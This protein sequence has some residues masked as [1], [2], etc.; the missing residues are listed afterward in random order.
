M[1]SLR[2]KQPLVSVVMPTYNHAQFIGDAIGSVLDQTYT[3]I[4]LIIIDN[5]SEDNTEE[6]IVSFSDTRIKYEKFRNNGIIAASR[7]VGISQSCGKYIA[8]LDSDDMWKPTK[9]EKQIKL[10]EDND[11]IFLVYTRYIIVKDGLVL[12]TLP[13]RK[14]LRSG[15]VFIPLF[16]SNNFIGTSTVLLRNFVNEDYHFDI[17]IKFRAIEDYDL[18]LRIAKNKRIDYV[19]EPLVA[20]REHGGNTSI[21]I[22]PYFLR[23][24]HVVKKKP[25]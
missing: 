24:L 21:G 23:Y 12:K 8:F 22:K 14:K 4:E 15:N 6:I 18:W 2:I 19:D 13:K 10:L 9:I 20:Y 17:D 16:L 1:K 11:N 25:S 3:N 7:N 5:Y